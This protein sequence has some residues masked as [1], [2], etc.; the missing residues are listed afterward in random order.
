MIISEK[1]EK[2]NLGKIV[3]QIIREQDLD[4]LPGASLDDAVNEFVE[5][6]A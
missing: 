6:D 4:C 5:K 3:G 1:L 2:I